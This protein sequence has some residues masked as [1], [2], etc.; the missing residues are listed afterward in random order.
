MTT[1]RW[2]PSESSNARVEAEPCAGDLLRRRRRGVEH[3]DR[4]E[5]GQPLIAPAARL[6][7]R[8]RA[9]AAAFDQRRRAAPASPG[10]QPCQLD[11]A[12]SPMV[13]PCSAAS[14]GLRGG[15]DAVGNGLLGRVVAGAQQAEAVDQQHLLERRAADQP[16]VVELRR[17]KRTGEPRFAA[18]D[19][20]HA[21]LDEQSGRN[22]AAPGGDPVEP[23]RRL[24]GVGFEM[25]GAARERVEQRRAIAAVAA[26]QDVRR[27]G[28]PE[29]DAL[30]PQMRRPGLVDLA[31]RERAASA[32]P[33]PRQVAR[34]FRARRRRQGRAARRSPAAA[35]RAGRRADLREIEILERQASRC[36]R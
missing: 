19:A 11:S 21:A 33:S 28:G 35:R 6:A 36:R 27:I 10:S 12:P 3:E 7:Q 5:R 9:Q 26:R 8:P 25:A 22:H 31:C 18:R 29:E 16:A 32:R 1:S 20:R 4:A 2:P 13:M 30:A 17:G 23:G 15:F 24:V 34:H 14:D